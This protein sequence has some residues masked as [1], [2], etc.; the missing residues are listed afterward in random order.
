MN[1]VSILLAIITDLHISWKNLG[2][3]LS[4]LWEFF[5]V[6][7]CV[8]YTAAKSYKSGE[9]RFVWNSCTYD[10]QEMFQF[11]VPNISLLPDCL[12]LR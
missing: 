10:S 1:S 11:M 2:L 5:S 4:A 9:R 8:N 6:Y 7:I 12:D 3:K